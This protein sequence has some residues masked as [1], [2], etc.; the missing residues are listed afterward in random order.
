MPKRHTIICV[1]FDWD[2]EKNEKLKAERGISFEDITLLLGSGQLWA[3]SDHWNSKEYPNQRVFLLPIDNY[4][5]LVPFVMDGDTF[6][7]K[8]AFPIRKATKLFN[9]QR[10]KK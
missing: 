5:Y 7:L 9:K 8:T 6:F 1:K 4:T 2:P 3:I 10:G